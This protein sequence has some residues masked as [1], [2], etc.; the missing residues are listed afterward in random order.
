MGTLVTI[1]QRK[2]LAPMSEHM[3]LKAPRQLGLVLDD[4]RLRGMN[5]LERQVVLRSL[6][7]LM[8]EASGLITREAGDDQ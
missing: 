2:E 5:P 8:H 7:R 1:T 3:L 6:A 4:M